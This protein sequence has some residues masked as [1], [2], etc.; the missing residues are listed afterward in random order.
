M[1]IIFTLDGVQKAKLYHPRL[2]LYKIAAG[3]L[4]RINK[5]ALNHLSSPF[6]KNYIC[7][8]SISL[9]VTFP[10]TTKLPRR[11]NIRKLQSK[12]EHI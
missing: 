9:S 10:L 2:L 7:F 3:G 4:L 5:Q 6:L 11:G 12:Y 1:A 8:V